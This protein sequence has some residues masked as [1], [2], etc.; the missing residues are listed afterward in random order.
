MIPEM[1]KFMECKRATFSWR[2]IFLLLG[3]RSL[4]VFI[5]GLLFFSAS[6]QDEDSLLM[7]HQKD[8]LYN[9]YKKSLRVKKQKR[10]TT[11][12][13]KKEILING[14]RFRVYNNWM[15]IGTG[16]GFN[17]ALPTSQSILDVNL[18]FHIK[19]KYIQLGTFLSGDR[20]LSFNN[21]NIHGCYGIRRESQQVNKFICIGPSFSWGFP[22]LGAGNYSEGSYSAVGVYAEGQWIFKIAYDLGI[23]VSAFVDANSRQTVG[24]LRMELYFSGAYRGEHKKVKSWDY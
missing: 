3:K 19:D 2:P 11:Y 21:Y 1:Y 9:A 17:S 5:F 7:A 18:H 13:S 14:K 20:F 10:D 4:L 8:S 24:G 15:N 23:G 16:Q 12:N 6:A 22:Y